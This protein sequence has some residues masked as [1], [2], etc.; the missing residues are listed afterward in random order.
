M[1]N[2]RFLFAAAT[3]VLAYLLLDQWQAAHAP[4]PVVMPTTAA[5]N[6]A[7]SAPTSASAEVPSQP[8]AL[9]AETPTTVAA[10][11]DSA[12]APV[13]TSA[14]S[15]NYKVET[16]L[17]VLEFSPEGAN[18][19]EA[20][21]KSYSLSLQRKELVK[22]ISMQANT[23]LGA[24][25][26]RTQ[27]GLLSATATLPNHLASYSAPASPMTMA[28]GQNTLEV[29][30]TWTDSTGIAVKKIY[31]FTRGSYAINVR[32]EVSNNSAAAITANSYRQF[33]QVEPPGMSA[34][35]FS[36]PEQF[37][38]VGTA[39]YS[40][41]KRFEKFPIGSY[42]ES[43]LDRSIAGGWLASLKHHF[44]VSWIP[45]T[46]EPNQYQTSLLPGD[47]AQPERMLARQQGP[48]VTIAPN[49]T[50]KFAATLYIGPK[51]Q[52]SLDK[53]APGLSKTVDY[54]RVTI[55]SEPL[56]WLLNKLHSIVKNW[57]LAIILLVVIIKLLFY[58]LSEKQFRSS[59]K[60]KAIAPRM[61]EIKRRYPED[62]QKQAQAQMELFAKEKVNPI[63]GCLPILLQIPVFFGLYWVLVE[64]VE[65][66]QAPFLFWI[67]DLTAADPYFVLPVL[68][69][70]VM[71]LTSKLTPMTGMDPIQQ[72][73]FTYM[74]LFFGVM[75]AFFPAGLVLYWTVNGLLTLAQQMYINKKIDAEMAV[76]KPA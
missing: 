45:S 20:S 67:K 38:Y 11:P 60:M 56:Y 32:D 71:F 55:F 51:L 8:S 66:R 36:S 18:I 63:A 35:F 69:A 72:K 27:S 68:N 75:M 34:S 43:N 48:V 19:V 26:L 46:T 10:T 52:S 4:L 25:M 37:S 9:T 15:N 47:A 76:K 2:T 61:E 1:N 62:R 12:S 31:T 13:G 5:A 39:I 30:F 14:T 28:E 17:F 44:F 23:D 29:P 22:L 40:P 7:S 65:L 59:A 53:L 21:L 54:G 64:S 73:M 49:S 6:T 74:P 50:A 16:D 3:A 57:G 33:I 42:R 58:K 24:I 41:E 70:L